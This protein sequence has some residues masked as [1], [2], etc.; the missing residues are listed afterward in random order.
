MPKNFTAM[1]KNFTA[2]PKNFSA[3][4]KILAFVIAVLSIVTCSLKP[5]T[6]ICAALLIVCLMNGALRHVAGRTLV[7]SPLLAMILMFHPFMHE[8]H[9]MFSIFGY[10]ATYEGFISALTLCLR[11]TSAVAV[12]SLLFYSTNDHE[13]IKGLANLRVP[14]EIILLVSLMARYIR[15]FSEELARMVVTQKSRCFDLRDQN[16]SFRRRLRVLAQTIGIL[17]IRVIEHGEQIRRAMLSRCFGFK[18]RRERPSFRLPDL[19]LLFL[20]LSPL[21]LELKL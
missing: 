21:I 12:A 19:L 7:V 17:F 6:L 8:G 13:L 3:E 11:I 16:I 18:I 14:K 1:P 10:E 15:L 20:S 2:M 5:L 4:T 9:P